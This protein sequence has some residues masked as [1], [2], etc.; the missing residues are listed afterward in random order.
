MG[1]RPLLDNATH[2]LRKASPDVNGEAAIRRIRR[3]PGEF[4]LEGR[5]A[6][7]AATLDGLPLLQ[8]CS[9]SLQLLWFCL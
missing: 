4:K 1:P 6:D 2:T 3:R 9:H 7:V 5:L 8:R